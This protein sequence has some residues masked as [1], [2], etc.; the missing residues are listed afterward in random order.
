M[1]SCFGYPEE[2]Q[3]YFQIFLPYTTVCRKSAV[4]SRR[5]KMMYLLFVYYSNKTMDYLFIRTCVALQY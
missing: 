4:G 5:R 2:R 3:Q 1:F